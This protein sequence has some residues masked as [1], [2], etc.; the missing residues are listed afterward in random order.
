VARRLT[1]SIAKIDRLAREI[2]DTPTATI[3]S[4]CAKAAVVL[5]ARLLWDMPVG[6]TDRNDE[7]VRR[8][9]E[10]PCA[11]TSLPVPVE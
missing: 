7:D 8:L 10:A 11:V 6:P 9:I 5:Y 3:E 1:L 2:L 4:L